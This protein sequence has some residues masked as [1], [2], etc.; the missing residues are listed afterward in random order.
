MN[1]IDLKNKVAIVTGGAQG[2]GLAIVEKFL[3]SDAKVIIWDKDK[4]MMSS[5][6]LGDNVHTVEVDV[7]NF[8]SVNKATEQSFVFKTQAELQLKWN[9][10]HIKLLK[11]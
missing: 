6:N 10:F 4:E 8:D 5:L 2:F 1:K 9:V 11:P 7:T 3:A